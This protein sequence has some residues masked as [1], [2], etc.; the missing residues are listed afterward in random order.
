MNDLRPLQRSFFEQPLLDVA[1]NLIGHLLVRKRGDELLVGRIVETEA[2]AG[3]TDPSAHSFNGVSARCFAMFGP[4]GRS[5]VYATQGRCHCINI[6]AEGS[7]KGRGVLI[8]AIEPVA[9]HSYMLRRRQARISSDSSRV[10]LENTPHELG[11]GPGK[12]EQLCNE[13]LIHAEF[14]FVLISLVNKISWI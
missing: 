7:C 8:R 1:K 2:Y 13:S 11:R 4:A 6:I 3:P 14:V 10:K 12:C 9:G 5:Y